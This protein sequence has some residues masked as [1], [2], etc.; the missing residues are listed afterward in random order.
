MTNGLLAFTSE[1][2]RLG[3]GLW[4]WASGPIIGCIRTSFPNTSLLSITFVCFILLSRGVLG[5]TKT[6]LHI[7]KQCMTKIMYPLGYS[8]DENFANRISRVESSRI[9]ASIV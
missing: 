4:G 8:R 9:L 2:P 1:L 6:A 5:S 3:R 7:G